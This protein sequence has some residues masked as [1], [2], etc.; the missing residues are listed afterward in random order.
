MLEMKLQTPA[1]WSFASHLA[2]EQRVSSPF[3]KVASSHART[4]RALSRGPLAGLAGYVTP[5]LIPAL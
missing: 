1:H 3:G 4:A 2:C 5:T